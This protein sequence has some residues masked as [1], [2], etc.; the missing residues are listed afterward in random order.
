MFAVH[1]ILQ[2][3]PTDNQVGGNNTYSI[4]ATGFIAN[5]NQLFYLDCTLEPES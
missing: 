2:L 5:I 1:A 3:I 4:V